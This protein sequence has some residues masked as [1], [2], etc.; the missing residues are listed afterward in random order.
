MELLINGSREPITL[1]EGSSRTFGRAD[2]SPH[3]SHN[4]GNISR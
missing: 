1:G 2:Y 3:G 4:A